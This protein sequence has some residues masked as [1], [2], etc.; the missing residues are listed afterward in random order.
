MYGSLENFRMVRNGPPIGERV[1]DRV[2][3]GAVGQ[4]GVD[5]RRRLV[6]ATADLA[7][8]LVD[9]APEVRLVDELHVA[10]CSSLPL[11]ST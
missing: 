3:T 1:D 6:D 8:D 7:H 9:D 4:A 2:D 11:R 5:H 10:S